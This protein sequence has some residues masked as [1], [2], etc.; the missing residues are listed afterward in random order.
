MRLKNFSAIAASTVAGLAFTQTAYGLERKPALDLATAEV[1]ANACLKH[2][3]ET[4]Y[5]PINVVIVDD[6]GNIILIK[7]Q[8]G[9]CKACGQIAEGK[10]KT[11]ALFNL[12]TRTLETISFGEKKDGVGAAIPGA[13]YVDGIIVFPGG[14][15]IQI[16]GKPIG[17]VGVSGASRDEDESCALA[18]LEAAKETLK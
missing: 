2:Q 12:T 15:P 3:S 4:K 10:A 11:A 9:A 8:D 6:G 18:G 13:P 17:A 5:A 7:R 1:I 14:V 16:D